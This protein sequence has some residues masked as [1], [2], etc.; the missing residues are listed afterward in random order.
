MVASALQDAGR[1]TLVGEQTAGTGTLL[2]SV[3]LDD[4]SLLEIG[5]AEWLTRNG[6][7]VWH[8][9]VVPDIEVA[10]P[11]GAEPILPAG[12]RTQSASRSLAADTQLGRAVDLLSMATPDPTQR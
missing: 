2:A 1:A 4:G 12:L 9:G 3:S 11:A 7:S 6:R 10:L 8:V 5:T